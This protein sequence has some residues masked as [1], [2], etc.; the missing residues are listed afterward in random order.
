VLNFCIHA[1]EAMPKGG[2]LCIELRNAEL[3]ERYA[4]EHAE[5]APGQYVMLAVSDNGTG[6]TPEVLARAFEPFFTTKEVGKGS[7]L[8][9]SM[10]FGFVKQSK[11]HVRIYS[12]LGQG[13][14][15]R[16]YLPRAIRRPGAAETSPAQA[17][18]IGGNERVLLVEDDDMVREHLRSA[19]RALG[20]EVVAVENGPR[21]IERLR[22]EDVFDL[23]LTD[24]VMP[25]GLSGREVAEAARQL[26]P[27]LAVLFTS[28]YAESAIVHHGRL[29]PGVHLIAKPFHR[30]ELAR[31]VREA[32][33][34]ARTA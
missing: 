3:D 1:R 5:P 4:E 29:E 17:A 21:A 32:L 6:M 15:V 16:L 19:L 26:R 20:Y 7:G 12:E 34:A 2:Q 25:G 9:L 30:A 14:T 10:V 23:L 13:T 11:G 24:V 31:K 18:P 8:G 22:S 27:Q 33:S 28:G